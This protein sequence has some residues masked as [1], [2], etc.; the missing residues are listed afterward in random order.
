M[1]TYTTISI[2]YNP[3]STGS[4]KQLADALQQRLKNQPIPVD[5]VPTKHAGHAEE[6]AYKLATA[7][8][9]P[10]IISSSGDGG[11]HEVINGVMR[12]QRKGATPI[13]GLLPAGNANDHFQGVHEY[14]DIADAILADNTKPVD[15]LRFT[16]HSQ[17]TTIERYAHSYIGVGLTPKAGLELNKHRL[18]PLV[19]AW[20]VFRVLLFLRPVHLRIAGKIRAYDSLIFSNVPKMSKVLSLSA[21]ASVHD[22]K[23]EV[24]AFRRRNKLQL[25][26]TLLTA[27]TSGLRGE[28]QVT[29]YSFEATKRTLVQLDGE[30]VKI[31]PKAVTSVTIAPGALQCVI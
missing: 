17:G 6:L 24:T 25:I 22:G 14:D 9:C 27:T 23:F 26:R 13:V 10:L 29:D 1:T 28:H 30:I 3:N 12:A 16:Y 18:N 7:S 31:D 8:A 5:I 4:A 15:L 20:I 11:Y 19:E 21:V 2:I